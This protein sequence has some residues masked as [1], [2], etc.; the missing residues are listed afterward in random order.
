MVFPKNN[1]PSDS[2]P[3][4]KEVENKIS[5][6]ETAVSN[7]AINNSARDAT[8][9]TSINN[10]LDLMADQVELKTY[11]VEYGYAEGTSLSLTG[12]PGLP[13]PT[14]VDTSKLIIDVNL[15]KP[16]NL[17][18]NFSS[19]YGVETTFP[20]TTIQY[21]WGISVE[22]YV[23]DVMVDFQNTG[24]SNNFGGTISGTVSDSGSINMVK[25]VPVSAGPHRVNVKES[26]STASSSG[27]TLINT[28]GD[29]LIVTVIQ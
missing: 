28:T 11:A 27:E 15:N 4:G 7:N 8:N 24:K 13:T 22:V 29:S 12:S 20:S 18:I 9:E 6:I 25:I 3:W 21:D 1:L 10:L 16:R 19:Y 26:F 2:V 17:L 23:D 14:Y 5:A